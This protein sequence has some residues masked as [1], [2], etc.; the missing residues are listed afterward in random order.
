MHVISFELDYCARFKKKHPKDLIY[1]IYRLIT[2][3]NRV[4]SQYLMDLIS[5]PIDKKYLMLRKECFGAILLCFVSMTFKDTP[6]RIPFQI[7]VLQSNTY[8]A[9]IEVHFLCK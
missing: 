6:E 2:M 3:C 5:S 9:I 4:V 8:Y 1:F 7:R